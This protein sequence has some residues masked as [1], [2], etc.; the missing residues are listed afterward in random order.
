LF[1]LERMY[2]EV[3]YGLRAFVDYAGV[4]TGVV[5]LDV[6][7]PLGFVD[8]RFGF[9]DRIRPDPEDETTWRPRSSVFGVPFRVHL[10]F[11]Q[12]Y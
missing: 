6:A 4:Q 3:G 1:G 2:L 9:L 7:V 11:T 5:A 8:G 10:T 12:T